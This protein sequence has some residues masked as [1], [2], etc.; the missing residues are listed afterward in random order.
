MVSSFS[1]QESLIRTTILL[2]VTSVIY[3]FGVIS[4]W[5]YLIKN[6][7]CILKRNGVSYRCDLPNL[8]IFVCQEGSLRPFPF[9]PSGTSKKNLIIHLD[10][11]NTYPSVITDEIMLNVLVFWSHLLKLP[12]L[13]YYLGLY[14]A[15]NGHVINLFGLKY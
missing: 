1:H 12:A 8:C 15:H 3:H 10:E 14:I 4:P 6:S 7:L 5:P 11:V 2:E 13:T 9:K